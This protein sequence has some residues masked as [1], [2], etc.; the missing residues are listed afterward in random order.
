VG[1][2]LLFG[3]VLCKFGVGSAKIDL[4]LK[5][6]TYCSGDMI[7]GEYIINGGVAEQRLKRVESDLVLTTSNDDRERV[8]HT[9]TIYSSAVITAQENKVIGLSFNIKYYIKKN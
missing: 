2:F 6:D 4:V 5:G 1:I 7:K 9:N 8:I 3:K